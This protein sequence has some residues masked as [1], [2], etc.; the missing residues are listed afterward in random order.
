MTNCRAGIAVD[1]EL[2][3]ETFSLAPPQLAFPTIFGPAGRARSA[4][5]SKDS[6]QGTHIGTKTSTDNSLT[7]LIP[8]YTAKISSAQQ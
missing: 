8:K 3:F 7:F 2:E 4:I 1:L 6:S 5:P